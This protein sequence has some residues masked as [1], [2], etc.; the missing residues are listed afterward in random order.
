MVGELL[1]I[2]EFAEDK[3]VA[4]NGSQMRIVR[5][6]NRDAHRKRFGD[7]DRKRVL[8]CWIAHYLCSRQECQTVLSAEI[9]GP[10]DRRIGSPL[11]LDLPPERFLEHAAADHHNPGSR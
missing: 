4:I 3:S 6:N 10:S 7:G 2:I 11:A 1:C 5:G 9:A 8:P